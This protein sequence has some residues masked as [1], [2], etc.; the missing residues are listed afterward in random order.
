LPP[1]L[2][3][4][5]DSRNKHMPIANLRLTPRCPESTSLSSGLRILPDPKGMLEADRPFVGEL[6]P[7]DNVS[8]A[9]ELEPR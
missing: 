3:E 1:Q 4:E 8:L 5:S 7:L 6:L 9:D 2:P